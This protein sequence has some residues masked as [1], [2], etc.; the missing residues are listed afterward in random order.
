MNNHIG[1]GIFETP[2]QELEVFYIC[3][4]HMHYIE[5]SFKQHFS[6]A[7]EKNLSDSDRKGSITV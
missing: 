3:E 1:V 6:P 4:I 2:T 7:A 5:I